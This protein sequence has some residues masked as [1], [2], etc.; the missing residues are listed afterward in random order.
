MPLSRGDTR[1]VNKL[2][3][4]AAFFEAEEADAIELLLPLTLAVETLELL[5]RLARLALRWFLML[6]EEL[7]GVVVL[8]RT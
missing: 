1:C 3:V 4:E 7:V 2:L 5:A 6:L 8:G